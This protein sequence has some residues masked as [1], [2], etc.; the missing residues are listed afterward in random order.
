MPKAILEFNLDEPSEEM[1]F[2][3]AM[4]ATDVYLCLW[5][6]SEEVFRPARKHGYP[7]Y[8][9]P[10]MNINEWSDETHAVVAKLEEMFYNLLNER[11]VRPFEELE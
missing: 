7:E 9:G 2:K 8:L 10:M 5:D 3:R 11:N 1:A 6:L 4:K